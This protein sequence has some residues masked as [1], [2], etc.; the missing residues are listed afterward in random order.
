M[1]LPE[2]LARRWNRERY[3]S[4]HPALK[5]AVL[6]PEASP[7]E[8][9]RRTRKCRAVAGT[10]AMLHGLA[11]AVEA[12][13][14]ALPPLEGAVVFTG[15]RHEELTELERDRFWR[16]FE[17]P[18]YEHRLGA[19][20]QVMAMECEAHELHLLDRDA[21]LAGLWVHADTKPCACG[22]R[23]PRL[24][25]ID[26]LRPSPAPAL[27]RPAVAA[28]VDEHGDEEYEQVHAAGRVA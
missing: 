22:N 2:P 19:D 17:T 16:V 21:P 10:V 24:R 6:K 18:V 12:G 1:T 3:P 13:E 11:D 7:R 23:H 4:F 8:L 25:H 5:I 15:S 20:G 26:R 9:A 28:Y 14:I 27:V